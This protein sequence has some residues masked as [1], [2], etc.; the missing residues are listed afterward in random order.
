MNEKLRD[1]QFIKNFSKI[2][3]RGA[4]KEENVKSPN[5]Y[6]LEISKENLK[7]VKENI[8]RKIK[9]LYKDYDETDSL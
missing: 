5:L 9:D 1:I 7:R 8:D 2:T 6:T 3:V 4:C